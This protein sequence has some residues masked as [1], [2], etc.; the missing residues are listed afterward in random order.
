MQSV[1]ILSAGK[2]KEG[3]KGPRAVQPNWIKIP[4]APSGLAQQMVFLFYPTLWLLNSEYSISH[5]EEKSMVYLLW[6]SLSQYVQCLHKTKIVCI[7]LK[8][9]L[10]EKVLVL[11]ST[12]SQPILV[13]PPSPAV[14]YFF[15]P[16]YF[17]A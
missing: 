2:Q 4:L 1:N 9:S 16:V 6:L 7:V 8:K 12:L 15:K 3:S 10:R 17:L 11:K 13:T 5:F 14:A